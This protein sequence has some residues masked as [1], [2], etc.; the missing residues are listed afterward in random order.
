MVEQESTESILRQLNE[1]AMQAKIPDENWYCS[2]EKKEFLFKINIPKLDEPLFLEVLTIAKRHIENWRLHTVEPKFISMQALNNDVFNPDKILDNLKLRINALTGQHSVEA[3]KKGP[4][5]RFDVSLLRSLLLKLGSAGGIE[6]P[7]AKLESYGCSVFLPD[8]T[9]T[10]FAELAGYNK[11][12][13]QIIESVILP[14][15]H[16]DVFDKITKNTRKHYEANKP[17]AVLFSGP[18]GVGKTSMARAMGKETDMP[19][20]YVPLENILSAYYGESTKRL[21][22]IFDTASTV[23]GKGIL[24]FLD[25]IDSLATSRNEKLFE[26]TRQLL[27]VLLRKLDGLDQRGNSL[28]IGATNRPEDLDPALLSR[29]DSQV[30]F[31]LPGQEDIKEILSLY[32]IQLKSTEKEQLASMIEGFS[33]RQIRDLCQRSERFHARLVIQK[34]EKGTKPSLQ[35]YLESA[36]LL[37]SQAHPTG[38]QDLP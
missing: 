18:P 17:R 5:N 13:N 10:G 15:T 38:L 26:A 12:K 22:A 23:T 1:A 8:K 32:A 14:M 35:T 20:V 16:S 2:F 11:V 9:K 6:D 25:E 30:Y 19:V 3:S 21:A 36:N 33:P 7:L 24:L 4:I 28:T 29:F 31:P 27:S 37:K 34:I